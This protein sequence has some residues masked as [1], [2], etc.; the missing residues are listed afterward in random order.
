MNFDDLKWFSA[1]AS[2]ATAAV[3]Y[4]KRRARKASIKVENLVYDKDAGK[5][6][7]KVVNRGKKS[8]FVK[9]S[10]RLVRFLDPV[11]LRNK[12]K[13][14]LP[15]LAGRRHYGV[16][17]GYDLLGELTDAAC[18]LAGESRVFEYYLT[19]D[20]DIHPYDTIRIDVPYGASDA[21]EAG[22]FT[23]TLQA[24]FSEDESVV[25]PK[26]EKPAEMPFIEESSAA[27][28]G[29]ILNSVPSMPL[30]GGR[31][32]CEPQMQDV[33]MQAG[34][35]DMFSFIPPGPQP[36]MPDSGLP[37]LGQA[38]ALPLESGVSI[39]VPQSPALTPSSFPLE[40]VCFCCGKIRWLNW[41]VDNQYYC[42]ECKDFLK[43]EHG[44]A[45]VE[46]APVASLT[47]I[48]REI[49]SVLRVNAEL[50]PKD[51]AR[52]IKEKPERVTRELKALY[53]K[54]LLSRRKS[55]QTFKYSAK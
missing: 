13:E 48:Q 9:P 46:A 12:T 41:T 17:R 43:E 50:S 36:M 38:P 51:V 26:V 49:M 24:R 53:D 7:L 30:D 37:E 40:S 31:F 28:G 54:Q 16:T 25:Q 23:Q 6:E 10:L 5:L 35:Q 8:Q 2:L 20:I 33:G 4:Q 14:D 3:I 47:T 39:E 18:L 1:A 34:S 27:L 15:M 21:A 22:Y 19:Y 55:G 45:E 42:D 11:E 32:N 52:K 29:D 44:F